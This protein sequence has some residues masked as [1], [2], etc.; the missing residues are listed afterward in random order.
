MVVA[1]GRRRRR[2][3]PRWLVLV[4]LLLLTF[5]AVRA[6]ASSGSSGTSRRLA[7]QA[8]VDEMRP[9]V[10]QSTEQGAD[11]ADIR[12][13]AAELGRS[14]LERRLARLARDAMS[15]YRAVSDVEPPDSLA[16]VHDL[17]SSA[18]YMRARAANEL[19]TALP[20]ALGGSAPDSAI[21]ALARTGDE[22]A[23]ADATYRVFARAV[24]RPKGSTR[25]PL[26]GSRWVTEQGAWTEPELRALL[27]TLQASASLDPVHDLAVLLVN[28]EPAA[29]GTDGD[30]SVLPP[31]KTLRLQIVVA[32]V[33]NE[34]QRNVAVI[35]AVTTPDGGT[36]TARDFVDLE[37]GQ[38]KTVTLGGLAPI[39]NAPLT[40]GV[41][42]GPVAGE[43]NTADNEQTKPIIVR[44]S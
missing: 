10:E 38:R 36:D 30:A 4:I 23:A 44:S 3:R 18:L 11:L 9:H 29:V 34:R 41:R 35:A 42:I 14:G 22:L 40:L 25:A 7:E 6:V 12:E 1:A 5:L 28:T 20:A 31:S 2:R 43:S 15:I 37:P 19:A 27:S 32:N 16:G 39:Q 26:P 24:P 13:Q 21:R 17:L 8:Y 33:G